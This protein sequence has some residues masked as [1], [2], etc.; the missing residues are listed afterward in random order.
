MIFT[1]LIAAVSSVLGSPVDR[2]SWERAEDPVVTGPTT[3]VWPLLDDDDYDDGYTDRDG[4]Y[5]QFGAGLVTTTD[6]DGPDEDIEFDEGWLASGAIGSRFGAADDNRFAFDLE[7]EVLWSDQDADDSGTLQAV[8]DVTVLAGL[9]NG[10]VDFELT[11]S[12]SLYAGAGIGA[13]GMD[14]G[15]TSDAV[16]DFD[17]EDGPFLAWQAKAGLRFYTRGSASFFL[18]YRFLNIDDAEIDDDVGGASFDLQ[19]SQHVAEAG[20]RFQL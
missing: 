9:I 5:L 18:G 17:E 1:S 20:V 16:N 14:V 2:G 11:R 4:M 10:L 12:F 6:S 19:T 13:A 7:L 15:T 3:A 8:N